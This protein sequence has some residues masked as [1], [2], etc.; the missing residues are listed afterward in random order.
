MSS[1]ALIQKFG[2]ELSAGTVLFKDGDTGKQMFVIQKGKIKISKQIDGKEKV[3]AL[4]PAGEFFGEMA[5]LNNEPRMATATVEE[6]CLL[7]V[8]DTKTFESMIRGNTEIALRMI[9][10]LAQRL[11]EAGEQIENMLIKDNNSKVIS[12]LAKM[13]ENEGTQ[14][15]TGI[16]VKATAKDL[17]LKTGLEPD[18]VSEILNKVVKAKL[19]NIQPNSITIS[20][21]TKLRKFLDFLTLKEQFGDF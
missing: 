19:I 2:K 6:D 17:A 16:V 18:T 21:V 11:K 1:G 10:K 4:L 12:T 7:L 8:I 15:E 20:D 3:L 5:I 13:G 14:T 9:K